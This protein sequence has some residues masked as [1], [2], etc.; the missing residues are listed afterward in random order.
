MIDN[1]YI[2][3]NNFIKKNQNKFFIFIFFIILLL[4]GLSVFKDYGVSWDE[5]INRRNG[6]ISLNHVIQQLGINYLSNDI[7]LAK[8]AEPLNTYKDKDYGVVF[9]MPVA[10]IE[11]IFSINNVSSQYYLRHFLTYLIFLVGV[12][13]VF[14]MTNRRF[15]SWKIGLLASLMFVLSP[16]IFA[17]SFYNSKD[18]VFMSIF[19]LG[20]N[21]AINFLCTPNIKNAIFHGITTALATDIR[22]MGIVI[23]GMTIVMIF[24]QIVK[25]EISYRIILVSFLI[26][27]IVSC[28]SII[29]FW[30]WLW[31]D[32]WIHIKEAIFNMAKFRWSEYNFYLGQYVQATNLPWHYILVWIGV[33][34][35]VIYLLTAAIA[36]IDI[37]GRMIKNRSLWRNQNEMQDIIFFGIFI[38]AISS[39]IILRSVL[40]DGWRHLYFIYPA[41]LL[42]SIRGILF[43]WKWV[44]STV[45]PK[46]ILLILLI[47]CFIYQASW[48]YINH[49][50]QN[51][52]FNIL[53]GNS[54]SQRFDLDYWGLSNQFAFKYILAHD[55]RPLISVMPVS[56]NP[57]FSGLSFISDKDKSRIIDT[58]D[59]KNADYLV[60][61][62][63]F[64]KGKP[65]IPDESKF[66]KVYEKMVDNQTIISVFKRK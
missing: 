29:L 9:D 25:R 19:A 15:D 34:T 56:D 7:E 21:T 3:K 32:P 46:L 55:D 38:G 62:Y 59:D 45:F 64:L 54:P 52:Y 58:Y 27:F 24:F 37:V 17:E 30:P 41:F 28:V 51:L 44:E 4:I 5:H 20:M 23:M 66:E 18:I 10:A 40:Y 8:F 35:P 14:K 22:V 36:C 26:Y 60:N 57:L 13:S 33:T 31:V 65:Y 61:N 11:R 42:L 16:R 48:I 49:P 2:L 50:L 1:V 53:A 12:F 47:S 43:L 63:R 6:L 39:V